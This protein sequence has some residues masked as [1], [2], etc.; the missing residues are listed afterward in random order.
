MNDWILRG[1]LIC[2]GSGDPPFR[3]DVHLQNGK[4]TAIETTKIAAPT[5][6]R[7]LAAQDFLIAPR[8]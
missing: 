6:A 3:G 4:I 1:G 2:D 8:V 7:V 5:D